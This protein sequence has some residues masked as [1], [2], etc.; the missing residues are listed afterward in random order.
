MAKQR[1]RAEARSSG[2]LGYMAVIT[3]RFGH[4]SRESILAVILA[5]RRIVR[6]G[7][8]NLAEAEA[9]LSCLPKRFWVA[10]LG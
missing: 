8:E 10:L 1:E 9:P 3:S 7:G 6:V 2:T 5:V 4:R